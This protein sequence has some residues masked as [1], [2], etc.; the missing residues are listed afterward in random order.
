MCYTYVIISP[1]ILRGEIIQDVCFR[2][3]I[4]ADITPYPIYGVCAAEV[5][6]DIL[7]GEHNIIRLDL[8]E[9]VGQSM[10]PEVDVGQIEGAVAMGLG[11][12]TCENL[13]YNDQGQLLTNSTWT[14]K[15]PGAKDIPADFNV[16]FRQDST[17]PGGVL[18]S[19][20]TQWC[21]LI[22]IVY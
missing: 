9:D 14:Y 6:V 13:I 5:Q 16:R 19:K 21:L 2:F 22:V 15:V 11:F 20:G 4:N 8:I 12:Y 7:T 10:S 3:S 17:N 1:T 18:N